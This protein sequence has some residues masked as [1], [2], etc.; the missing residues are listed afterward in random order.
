MDELDILAAYE[1]AGVDVTPD[2]EA[3]ISALAARFATGG[4][5]LETQAQMVAD[6]VRDA[7]NKY[8]P[9]PPPPPVP[10]LSQFG[11]QTSVLSDEAGSSPMNAED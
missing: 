8:V 5:S 6:L 3:F 11:V 9:P 4:L 2:I 1:D 10:Q 7:A